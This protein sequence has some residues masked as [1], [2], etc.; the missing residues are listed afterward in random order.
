MNREQN[1]PGSGRNQPQNP[2]N[3]PG[4]TDQD[5]PKEEQEEEESGNRREEDEESTPMR[6]RDQGNRGNTGTP[7]Q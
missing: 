7:K 1:R 5:R 6:D 2:S 3:R 4:V